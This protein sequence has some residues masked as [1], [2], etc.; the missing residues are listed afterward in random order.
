MGRALLAAQ[1]RPATPQVSPGIHEVHSQIIASHN[2]ML[3]VGKAQAGSPDSWD[4]S[5]SK[6]RPSDPSTSHT[7]RT[8]HT[9]QLQVLHLRALT[10]LLGI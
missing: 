10:S 4:L 3:C 9:L 5:A 7:G 1:L 6:R 8:M 2:S